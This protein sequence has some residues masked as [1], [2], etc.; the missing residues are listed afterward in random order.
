MPEHIVVV[1]AGQM[2]NGIAHVVAASGI[3]V[4]MIDVSAEAVARGRTTIEK[5][6]ARQVQKGTLTTPRARRRWAVFPPTPR[7]TG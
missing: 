1:G 4:T 6:L 3:P 5:N 7:S 2:G